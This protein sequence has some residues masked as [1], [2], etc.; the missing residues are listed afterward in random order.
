MQHSCAPPGVTS[1]LLHANQSMAL[2]WLLER[3][4]QLSAAT[5]L[6][7]TRVAVIAS[8]HGIVESCAV[9]CR[10]VLSFTLYLI[11]IAGGEDTNGSRLTVI[12]LNAFCTP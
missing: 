8:L 6:P 10:D 7:T 2:I 3:Q 1:V 11:K 4:K 5:A 9:V 12:Q